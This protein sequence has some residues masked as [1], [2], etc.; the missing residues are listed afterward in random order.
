MPQ[1][2]DHRQFY[3]QRW[4]KVDYVNSSKIGRT[5]A[6]LS[7]LQSLKL[8]N[9]RILDLGCGTGWLTA[10][11]GQFGPTTGVEL[12]DVAVSKAKQKYPYVKYY[13]ANILNWK[14]QPNSFDVVVSQEVIEHFD[15]QEVYIRI[16]H[17]L[18]RPGGYLILTTPNGDLYSLLPET[19][20]NKMLTQPVENILTSKELRKL[21]VKHFIIKDETTV[22]L[23]S[24]PGILNRVLGSTKLR[25]M[26][27]KIYLHR[28][29]DH[30]RQ[31]MG[32]G[33]NRVILAQKLPKPIHK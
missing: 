3:N 8:E 14:Y 29:L 16:C 18:I 19:V 20:V 33:M 26:L 7:Y 21:L 12:S 25:S 5:V 9:P 6:I 15:N 2:K 31:T 32:H 22:N 4:E 13:Q 27:A 28:N 23:R 24:L 11:L 10:I 1:Y 30:L 17:D